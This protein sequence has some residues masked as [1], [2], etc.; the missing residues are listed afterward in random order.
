M[1]K[2]IEYVNQLYNAD[3]RNFYALT[4]K[5]VIDTIITSPPYWNLK[6]YGAKGQVG[7]GQTKSDY[8]NDIKKLLSDWYEMLKSTGSLWLIADNYRKNGEVHLLPWEIAN[9]ASE[10][11]WKIRDFIIWD[12][13]YNVPWQ[14]KGQFRNTSEFIVLMTKT[15]TYQY[16]SDRIRQLDE[17]SKWWVDF[18]ERFNP[19]GKT[20]TNIWSFPIRRRGTWPKPSKVDHFCSLPGSLV[21]RIIEL[22][23]NV[24]NVV[25]DPFAGSGVVLAQ[26]KVMNR[27]YVGCELNPNYVKMF[28]QTILEV[29]DEWDQ[30]EDR[31]KKYENSKID[32][33]KTVMSLRGLKYSRQLAV[34]C[35]EL[36]SEKLESSVV[37][38][39]GWIDLPKEFNSLLPIKVDLTFVVSES[40]EKFN[41]VLKELTARSAKAPLS[42]YGVESTIS[43]MSREGLLRSKRKN[44]SGKFYLYPAVRT[45]RYTA[46][47][48][49]VG[50][51]SQDGLAKLSDQKRNI[52]LLSN[53]PVDVEWT[54][55]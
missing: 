9:C 7:Y 19:K 50:W 35:L 42:H 20:P 36:V 40:A 33:E 37:A 53:I 14:Q 39:I 43:F 44:K 29:K 27:T 1:A 38:A 28:K 55:S 2:K 34:S 8:I 47:N 24:G 54:I 4:G 51:L 21:G 18:P 48:S 46:F 31:R 25:A 10:V 49:M 17:I 23:T 45:R 11:G 52:P 6:D 32:F 13:Q 16:Y 26:A 41:K 3:T 12:K 22:T 15:D 5:D 30:L